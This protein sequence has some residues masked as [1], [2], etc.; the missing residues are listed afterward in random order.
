MISFW[1]SQVLEQNGTIVDAAISSLLC[2]SLLNT[3]SMGIGG[4]F[5]MLHY[6]KYRNCLF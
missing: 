2:N 1:N 3:Q 5:F 6:S 4:G